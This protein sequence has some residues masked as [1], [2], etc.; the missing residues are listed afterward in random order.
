[1]PACVDRVSPVRTGDAAYPVPMDSRSGKSPIP[2]YHAEV[3]VPS[4]LSNCY[5]KLKRLKRS[6]LENEQETT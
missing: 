2:L 1:M 4:L 3:F 6:A 5:Q